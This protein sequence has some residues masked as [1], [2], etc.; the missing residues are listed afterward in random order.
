MTKNYIFSEFECRLSIEETAELCFKNVRT[1]KEWDKG[2]PIPKVCKRLMRMS[3]KLE[4]SSKDEWKG[5]K[6]NNIKLELPTGYSVTPQQILIG[7][8]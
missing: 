3:M 8:A 1:V 2:Q 4:L 7:T 6:M 5:F